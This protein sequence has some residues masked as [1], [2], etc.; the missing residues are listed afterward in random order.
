LK[1]PRVSFP[2]AAVSEAATEVDSE[3]IEADSAVAV[4]VEALAAAIGA[5]TVAPLEVD[6]EG[7]LDVLRQKSLA[8]VHN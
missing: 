6:T 3:V 2:V 1:R 4:T 8:R 5:V 7:E